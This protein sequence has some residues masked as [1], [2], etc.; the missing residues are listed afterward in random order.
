M[1]RA[2]NDGKGKRL[3]IMAAEVASHKPPRPPACNDQDADDGDEMTR[4][5]PKGTLP[6][7]E[8]TR[9][10]PIRLCIVRVRERYNGSHVGDGGGWRLVAHEQRTQVGC[11]EPICTGGPKLEPDNK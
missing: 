6:V 1:R 2:W 8:T 10:Q 11:G 9:D 5:N 3:G 4:P 7:S